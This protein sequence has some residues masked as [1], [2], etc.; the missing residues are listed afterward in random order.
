MSPAVV[1]AGADVIVAGTAIFGA[2]RSR[3]A[4]IAEMRSAAKP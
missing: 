1:A 2:A 4:A 3:Q